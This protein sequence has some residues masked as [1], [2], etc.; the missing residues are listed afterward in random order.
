MA[1]IA[2]Y[3][4]SFHPV[5]NGHLDIIERKGSGGRRAVFGRSDKMQTDPHFK[6]YILCF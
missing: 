2:L 4:G 5:T 1:R 6:D 3:A